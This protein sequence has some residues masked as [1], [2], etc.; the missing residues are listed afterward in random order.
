MQRSALLYPRLVDVGGE[1]DE[2]E[3]TG[4]AMANL[5]EADTTLTVWAYGVTGEEIRG[6]PGCL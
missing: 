5:S 3:I 6:E 2:S 4:I 1:P